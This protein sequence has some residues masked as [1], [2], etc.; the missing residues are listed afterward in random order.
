MGYGSAGRRESKGVS[1]DEAIMVVVTD[2]CLHH[3]LGA[4]QFQNRA[5][6]PNR[7]WHPLGLD[8]SIAN[9]IALAVPEI[10]PRIGI[11]VWDRT[12]HRVI[13]IH[14]GKARGSSRRVLRPLRLRRA[15]V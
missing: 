6:S 10:A 15:G 14:D 8:R 11:H 2:R 9:Y 1:R 4:D 7:S 13:H 3:P 5:I 12:H